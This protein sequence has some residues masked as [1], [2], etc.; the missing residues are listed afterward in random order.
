MATILGIVGAAAQVAGPL[1]SGAS[2]SK[3]TGPSQDAIKKLNLGEKPKAAEYVPV[4]FGQEQLKTIQQ[5]IRNLT[6]ANNLSDWTNQYITQND[7][8][9]ARKTIPGYG[10]MMQQLGADAA[11]LLRGELPYDD[12][13]G[14]V[15]NR[16]GQVGGINIPG[17]AGPATA[18]DLGLSRLDAINTGSGLL[19][20]MV[21]NAQNISPVERQQTPN[22]SFISPIDRIRLA[23]SQN[24]TIQQSDQNRNNIEASVSPTDYA[25]SILSLGLGAG[26]LGGGGGGNI[27]GS[28]AGAG[29]ALGKLGGA[30]GGG[31]GGL[32]GLAGLFG[33]GGST[34]PLGGSAPSGYSGWAPGPQTGTYYTPS[35]YS[36][37]V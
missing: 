24:E 29:S 19:Q 10:A 17:T 22:Q 32:G 7:L 11:P 12:V 4:H 30:L 14:I 13:L 36:I 35:T 23:M 20:S 18:R 34:L 28:V 6:A 31:G 1:I 27:G 16:T 37:P 2:G 26:G 9:R 5:N 33:G 15:G 21:R 8:N 25:K 3:Q